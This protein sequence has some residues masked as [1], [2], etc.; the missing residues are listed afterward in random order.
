MFRRGV[1]NW[2]QAWL[3]AVQT[4]QT[5]FSVRR[6]QKQFAR[7]DGGPERLNALVFAKSPAAWRLAK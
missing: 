3:A 2:A 6:F 5:R 7:S 4:R 1:V